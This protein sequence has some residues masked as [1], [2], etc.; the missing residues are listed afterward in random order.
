MSKLR[1]IFMGEFPYP[2]GY[3]GTQ[4]IQTAIDYFAERGASI[5]VLSYG[6]VSE[7]SSGTYKGVHYM[8]MP[9][10][11]NSSP[12]SF[13]RCGL[14]FLRTAFRKG[15]HNVLVNYG[16]PAPDNLHLLLWSKRHGVKIVHW[17]VEDF[18][19][20]DLGNAE[21]G[22]SRKKVK[23][24][25]IASDTIKWFTNGILTLSS[26]LDKKYI[27]QGLR[28]QLVPVSTG[29]LGI[30]PYA[31][32]RIRRNV[33]VYAG[34]MGTKDGVEDLIEAFLDIGKTVPDAKLELVG[35]GA[36]REELQNQYASS[37]SVFF[38]GYCD[39]ETYN[40]TLASAQILCMT[41]I[42][43]PYANAG[44]P[45]KVCDYLATGRPVLATKVSDIERYLTD[46]ESALLIDSSDHQGM[47]EALKHLLTDREEADRIGANGRLVCEKYFNPEINGRLMESFFE[48]LLD[49]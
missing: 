49:S 20:Y 18:H 26:W 12:F 9:G 31:A 10:L 11:K 38:L 3:A 39:D 37:S 4:L 34:T 22:S 7:A 46:G 6:S 24:N 48:S 8:S 32:D 14:N 13:F 27:E 17:I 2:K 28:T 36:R 41:R 21:V 5:H 19:A 45:Y 30:R 15:E 43:T 33:I 40:D 1:I 23:L 25:R 42:S 44:F 35:S 29:R 16:F 47:V